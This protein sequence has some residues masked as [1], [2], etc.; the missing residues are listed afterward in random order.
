MAFSDLQQKVLAQSAVDAVHAQLAPLALFA[1]SY[2]SEIEG[3]FG[4]AVSVPL[5][6]LSAAGEFNPESNNLEGNNEFD[7]TLVNL[8]KDYVQS[9]KILDRNLAF[10]GID[11]ARDAG[12][13]I[14]RSLGRAFN[15]Y[16]IGLI[17]STN[18]ELTASFSP[19]TKAGIAKLAEI[20][21]TNDIPV[22]DT[23]VLVNP[24]TWAAILGNVADYAIFG[25]RDAFTATNV[26][27]EVFGFKAIC[28]TTALPS[29][30]IGA[31]VPATALA[32]VSMYVSPVFPESFA[33]SWKA[34]DPEMGIALSMSEHSNTATG[35]GYVSGRL[36]CGAK[37]IQPGKIVRLVTGS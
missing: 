28:A 4:Y 18:C 22:E 23:V 26:V 12:T 16:A 1:H 35:Y 15:N 14:G 7:G 25:N 27:K 17:N 24:A 10:T 37:L 11:F 34:A 20:A 29:G 2:N 9:M 36:V 3:K 33:A 8:D 21:Y 5:T 13:A 19:S 30:T 32:T 31:L 6:D